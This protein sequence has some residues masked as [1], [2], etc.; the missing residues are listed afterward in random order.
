MDPSPATPA[1]VS[2][3][4]R[5]DWLPGLLAGLVLVATSVAGFFL[6]LHLKDGLGFSG[7]QIGLLYALQAAMGVLAALPAGLGNDRLTS[8]TLVGVGLLG[9]AL[10]LWGMGA[11]RAYPLFL[12]VF[13]VY[14]LSNW[15]FKLSLDVQVL[16]TDCG[17]RT[18]A[19]LGLYQS[20]RYGLLAVGTVATGYL[21]AR[22]DFTWTMFAVAGLSALL[23][24]LALALPPTRVARV[25]LQDYRADLGDRR[26]LLFALWLF[27]FT[28]H[29]GAET[30]S[31][32]LFL[33]VD[34]GL[35]LEGIGWY[36]AVE[37]A[38]IIPAVLW[39]GRRACDLPHLRRLA[40]LG[41]L[42]SGLGHVG[43]VF[44]PVALS[45][46]FRAL[47]GLGDGIMLIVMYF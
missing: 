7:L 27:L 34:L 22:L 40:V 46:S 23:A 19:R 38:A 26:V 6:T 42:A 31:Y 11:A 45:V 32:G 35:G 37:Y 30:T 24:G 36:L 14:S 29:W 41:L 2:H 39:A 17:E 4:L 44:E 47:H 9:Q 28:L 16:K 13:V 18:G 5:A 25:R 8:R 15:V 21:L 20:L 3:P 10:G 43:M 12:L 1:T 33:R